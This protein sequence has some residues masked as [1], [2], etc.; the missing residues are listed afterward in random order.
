[1]T[2]LSDSD[3]RRLRLTSQLLGPPASHNATEI[4]KWF[5]AI[6]SQHLPSSEWAIGCRGRDLT[7]RDIVEAA[8]Q[9]DILRTWPMRGTLHWVPARDAGWMLQVAGTRAL[10]GL[11]ARW[12][13]VGLDRPF[14]TKAVDV[15]AKALAGTNGLTRPQ[16]VALLKK[17]GL[18]QRP[19]HGYQL[20]WYASQIGVTAIGP[21]QRFVLL[22]EWVPQPHRLAREAALAR[23]AL[24]Y[25]QSHGPAT[26]ADLA[27]WSGLTLG[28]T[29]H[30]IS[31]LGPAIVV[32]HHH[33]NPMLMPAEL[34]DT[35]DRRIK[36][37]V[38]LLASF[39][40]YLVGYRD[41]DVIFD[42]PGER[43]V[44]N[45]KNGTM[46][47]VIVQRGKVVGTWRFEKKGINTQ[48]LPPATVFSDVLSKQ[49]IRQAHNY[50]CF[51]AT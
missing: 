46:K 41:R 20:L 8:M 21:D 1:M 50:A 9:G 34:A 24:S 44:V 19:E 42:V 7:R 5:G 27:R 11:D 37:G 25:L 39:D 18:H 29:D 33:G 13:Q 47:A 35:A 30:A 38:R 6:Q 32:A 17:H 10:M 48:P 23:L 51:D 14:V 28:D 3:V 4:V 16:C 26:R 15:L 40:E 2:I 36:P 45:K 43:E 49:I 22:D 12:R 31:L